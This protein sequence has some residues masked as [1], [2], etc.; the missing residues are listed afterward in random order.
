MSPGEERRKVGFATARIR[1]VARRLNT[2]VALSSLV[3][4]VW[5]V[6][7]G[8]SL[9]RF[10]VQRWVPAAAALLAAIGIAAA[11]LLMRQRMVTAREAAV[12]ADRRA[13]AG[14]LL[15]T[16]LETGIGEWETPLDALLE[17]L[18]PPPI[19]VGRSTAAIALALLSL[20]VALWI[21]LPPR[22]QRPANAA[23]A[24]RVEE[25][26][27]K[28][29]AAAKEEPVEA[30]VRKELERLREEL[31]E[32]NFDAADWEAADSLGKE[33]ER[34]AE[35]AG[36]ELLKAEEAAT[37]LELAMNDGRTLERL[38]REREE[39]EQALM[40]LSD[41]KSENAEQAFQHAIENTSP[42]SPSQGDLRVG[43]PPTGQEP[44]GQSPETAD[45]KG[46]E[47]HTEQEN[48]QPNANKQNREDPTAKGQHAQQANGHQ[49]HPQPNGEGQKDH[50]P[51][52]Q[53]EGPSASNGQEGGRGPT[54]A[55]LDELKRALAQRRAELDKS[56][57]QGNEQRS[58]AANRSRQPKSG[59]D[60]SS[61]RGTAQQNGG[62]EGEGQGDGEGEAR[63][64]GKETHGRRVQEGQHASRSMTG[65][66]THGPA[67]DTDLVFA[68]R[69]E[70]DPS[71]LK[72]KP[73]PEGNGGDGTELL[74]LV[75]ANPTPRAGGKVTAGSG[76]SAEGEETP[77]NREG[78]YL[79]RNKAL[80]QRYF[81]SPQARH[82]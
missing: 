21:P 38:D 54:R 73:M 69:A 6:A 81:D 66:P 12:I 62:K 65:A 11:W 49:N 20:G 48:G 68:G 18:A 60:H 27:Q 52:A 14:G 13:N 37:N 76:R 51:N 17:R 63:G 74:G 82:P 24:S 1:R 28:L 42:S 57:G 8:I 75:A 71:R 43:E 3:G 72:M 16:R 80:I 55:Q 45:P 61:G 5:A 31:K 10:A 53:K 29:E 32:G 78:N 44:N 67:A 30:D 9:W 39:L 7:A 15:L 4:P 33:L 41:G 58:A 34:K 35:E 2:A 40:Q 19:A 46:Q 59:R 79:P 22:A 77:A 70:M 25:L 23:A 47:Q 26:A 36:A 50:A 56:F 64:E